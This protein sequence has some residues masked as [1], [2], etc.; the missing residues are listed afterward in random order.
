MKMK[1]VLAMLLAV[2]M[3]VTAT[4]A[5]TVAWLTTS[6]QEVENTFTTSDINITLSETDADGDGD[7]NDNDY[8]MVPGATI[9]KDPKVTVAEGSEACWLFVKVTEENNV[10]TYLAYAIAEGWTPVEGETGVYYR[11][12]AADAAEREFAV[13]GEGEYTDPM[14]TTDN[15]SDDVTITW[16]DN[17]LAVKP[18]VTKAMMNDFDTDNS[19]TL[20]EDEMASLP[21][22]TFKAYAVQQSSFDTAAKAWAEAVKLDTP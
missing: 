20:S 7:K 19:G 22:L 10:D 15:A 12:V 1:K 5:G 4:V 18:S 17:Q 11:Q 6:T 13:L 21:A 3:I 8:Q 9:E 2:L 14:G 16:G